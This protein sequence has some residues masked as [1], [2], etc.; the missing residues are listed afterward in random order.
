MKN[1]LFLVFCF[2]LLSM[3]YGQNGS[4]IVTQGP[5]ENYDLTLDGTTLSPISDCDDDLGQQLQSGTSYV[6]S[7]DVSTQQHILNGIST[8]DLIAIQ[9]HLSGVA[10]L[11]SPLKVLAADMDQDGALSTYDLIEMRS[12][13]IGLTSSSDS[14]HYQILKADDPLPN[15]DW[16]DFGQDFSEAVITTD[17]LDVNGNINVIMVKLGDVR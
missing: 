2:L 17:D 7:T 14:K 10:L 3:A 11:D 1:L 9:R 12:L 4:V 13:I 15:I 16:W 5:C 6:L 8:L